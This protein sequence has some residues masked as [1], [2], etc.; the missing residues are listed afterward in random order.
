VPDRVT[1][2][3]ARLAVFAALGFIALVCLPPSG[4]VQSAG[5]DL[6]LV[7]GYN[8]ASSALLNIVLYVPLGAAL[9]WRFRRLAHVIAIGAVVS[10]GVELLQLFIP[11]RHTALSDLV[12]NTAGAALGGLLAISPRA[13]ILPQ[14]GA[15]RIAAAAVTVAACAFMVL[16]GLL[17][18][19]SAPAG[20]YY[21][22]WRPG[23]GYGQRHDGVVL[24]ATLGDIPLPSSRLD[25]PERLRSMLLSRAPVRV[26]FV[27]GS[28]TTRLTAVFRV[29]AGPFGAGD[30]V[31]QVGVDGT[32]LVLTPRFRANDFRLARPEVQLEHAL[33]GIA[34]GDTVALSLQARAGPGYEV[35]LDNGAPSVVGFSVGRSWSL[36]YATNLRSERALRLMDHGWLFALAT[37][38]GWFAIRRWDPLV[39]LVALLAVSGAVPLWSHLLPTQAGT[40]VALAAGITVGRLIRRS[41]A[42]SHRRDGAQTS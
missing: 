6:C 11:G 41:V 37:L 9:W 22:Q 26:R 19:P 5:I 13:W 7:C 15:A 12:A 21:G 14:A 8:G 29:V 17:F 28:P 3:R 24:D 27:A 25:D 23:S 20:D 10:L 30:E 42:R 33:A 36:L 18:R 34:A 2:G 40:Y 1:D 35:I 39:A 4:S 31:L 16:A 38:V 32:A